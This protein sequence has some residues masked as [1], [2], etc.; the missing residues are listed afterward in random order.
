[1]ADPVIRSAR[2]FSS[3]GYRARDIPV[4]S[5]CIIPYLPRFVARDSWLV[6]FCRRGRKDCGRFR[7]SSPPRLA[8]RQ[9]AIVRS[10]GRNCA[11]EKPRAKQIVAREARSDD[12]LLSLATSANSATEYFQYS[13]T[14]TPNTLTAARYCLVISTPADAN[15]RSFISEYPPLYLSQRCRQSAFLQ[16]QVP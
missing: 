7:L 11:K 13:K 14:N 16:E 15:R 2:R 1:M 5:N 6:V 10:R 12:N 9:S 4:A 3:L 8:G